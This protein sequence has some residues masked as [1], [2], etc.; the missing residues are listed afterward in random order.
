M[1]QEKLTSPVDEGED[2]SVELIL[3][4]GEAVQGELSGG[5]LDVASHLAGSA[6]LPLGGLCRGQHRQLH[7]Q[8]LDVRVESQHRW[9]STSKAC[10]LDLPS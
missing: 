3:E 4:L 1:R 10:S 8:Q 2:L 6:S 5:G 7:L 9:V